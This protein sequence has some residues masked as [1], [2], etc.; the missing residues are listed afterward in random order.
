MLEK[1]SPRIINLIL[2]LKV[3]FLSLSFSAGKIK[4]P[5]FFLKQEKKQLLCR[6][7]FVWR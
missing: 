4:A 1:I 5:T 7:R 6:G 2:E 3:L